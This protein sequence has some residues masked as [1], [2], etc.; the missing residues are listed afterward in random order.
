VDSILTGEES[1]EGSSNLLVTRTNDELASAV[2]PKERPFPLPE[3]NPLDV[4]IQLDPEQSVE[5]KMDS[6]VEILSWSP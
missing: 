2:D 5:A 6:D 4:T 3:P 1:D